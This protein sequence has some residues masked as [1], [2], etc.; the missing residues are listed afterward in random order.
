MRK[1]TGLL[2]SLCSVV[3][4]GATHSYTQ[5]AWRPQL[6]PES[7]L[8]RE[9]EE[10]VWEGQVWFKSQGCR[11]SGLRQAG[12]VVVGGEVTWWGPESGPVLSGPSL[13]E[14]PWL[15]SG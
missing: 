14:A 2:L 1:G 13:G 8:G 5:A 6:F 4:L 3:D 15:P 9:W 11:K 10:D 7:D 12:V